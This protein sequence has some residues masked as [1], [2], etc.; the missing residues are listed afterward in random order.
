MKIESGEAVVAV[1]QNPREKVLGIVGE[2]N[3]AGLTIRSIDLSYF[4]DWITAIKTG[5]TYLPMHDNFFPMWRIERITR[6][7]SSEGM[8]SMSE[9]FEQRTGSNLSSF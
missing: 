1:L 5:E 4:E 8:Q 3:S 6:D 7:E 9:Q 2:L